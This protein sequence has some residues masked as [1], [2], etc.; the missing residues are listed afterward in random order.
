MTATGALIARRAIDLG[1]ATVANDV[2]FWF[3]LLKAA[4]KESPANWGQFSPGLMP[5]NVKSI[6]TKG[7]YDVVMHLT[8][9]Y[10]P[11]FFL[12]NNLQDTNNVYPLPSTAWNIDA[13]GGPH[14]T[15]WQNNPALDKKIYDYLNKQGAAVASFASNPLWKVVDVRVIDAA[16]NGVGES[17]AGASEG[18][19]RMQSG[20]VRTYAT[21]LFLGV[22]LIL[23]Y[24][25]WL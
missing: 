23:G 3:Y 9:P 8:G 13:A 11:G 25:L 20:S 17:V 5:E 10:N 4:V 19:R 22:V 18:L 14:L 21:S 6:S 1:A 12:N 15:N 2:V 24:Y 16:V 7:K